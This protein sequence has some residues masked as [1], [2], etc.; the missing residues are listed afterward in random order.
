MGKK[1]IWP[2]KRKWGMDGPFQ[3]RF[4][5]SVY[6]TRYCLRKYEMKITM[7]WT[8]GKNVRGKKCEEN[9]SEYHTREEVNWK[10]KK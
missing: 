7:V 2:S 10:G 4:D 5:G 3:S 6:R 9:V 1:N 8:C